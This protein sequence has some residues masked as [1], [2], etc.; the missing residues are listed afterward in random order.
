M[1]LYP[2]SPRD[3]SSFAKRLRNGEVVAIPTETVYGLAADA[4]QADAVAAIYSIK[5]RPQFNP[6]ICHIA[7]LRMAKQYGVFNETANKLAKEFWPGALTLV[8]PRK[9][10][11]KISELAS[12]GL[13]SL[14][15]RC[16]SHPIAAEILRLAK[17]PLAAPS[18]NPSGRLSPTRPED[19]RRTLPNI[20]VLDGGYCE[21]G[22]ESTIIGCLGD[23]AVYLRAGGISRGD[24]EACLGEPLTDVPTEKGDAARLAPG[25]LVRHYAPHVPLHINCTQVKEDMLLLGF[26]A[27]APADVADNLSETG[28]LCEATAN[29]F[30]CLHKL[31]LQAQAENKHIGV[32]PIPHHGLGEAINDRLSR[33]AEAVDK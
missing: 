29:L 6:L 27:D 9:D 8:V 17:R 11:C 13:H 12:A 22:V 14:A 33:A 10:N 19:V 3:I 15:L 5:E 32:M 21:V 31:D 26:G 25:R 28:D 4:T 30:A 24:I 20:D 1:T 16:P 18:A 2:A 23:M 7:S